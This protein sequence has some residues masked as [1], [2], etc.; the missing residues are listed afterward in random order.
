VTAINFAVAAMD[1]CSAIM[2]SI[3]AC[4]I[5]SAM[6]RNLCVSATVDCGVMGKC[7]AVTQSIVACALVTVT[8]CNFDIKMIATTMIMTNAAGCVIMMKAAGC[9]IMMKAA[10]CVIMM[11]AAG[12][13][14][15]M[16]A[17]GCMGT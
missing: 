1:M 13:V 3:L 11:K 17:A 8:F 16:K 15:M 7:S 10:G 4:I 6:H 2:L 5:A 9:V 14:I 12:G